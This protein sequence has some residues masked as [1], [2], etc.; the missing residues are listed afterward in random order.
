MVV[1]IYD[2]ANELE[3]QMRETQE[4]KDLKEAFAKLEADEKA[5]NLFKKF[6]QSQMTAQHKQMSG[7]DLSD[8]EIKEVQDLA[9][10]VGQEKAV[11]ELMEVER[12][13]DSMMQ[14]LNKTITKPIQEIYKD[15]MPEQQQG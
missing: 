15:V 9:K 1:N 8:D 10:Q 11:I 5:F 4:Y 12:R 3:R 7:Q 13:V 6:Q 2:T 14:E